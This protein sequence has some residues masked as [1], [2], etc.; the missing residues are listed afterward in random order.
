MPADKITFGSKGF[1][2]TCFRNQEQKLV[3][4]FID[5]YNKVKEAIYFSKN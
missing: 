5:F 4:E 2:V 3:G 1:L